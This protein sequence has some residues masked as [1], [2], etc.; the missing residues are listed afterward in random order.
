MG[1]RVMR[2]ARDY[3]GF[4]DPRNAPYPAGGI[5]PPMGPAFQLW[6]TTVMLPMSPV[7]DSKEDLIRWLQKPQ[8]IGIG[9]QVIT[10]NEDAA[11]RFVEVGEAP[12]FAMSRDGFTAGSRRFAATG[13]QSGS[14]SLW[15]SIDGYPVAPFPR[16]RRRRHLKRGWP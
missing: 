10:L 14:T 3:E 13:S 5:S 1:R 16:P 9:G 15:A 4:D 2:V 12:T 7:F 8:P 6:M 11:R